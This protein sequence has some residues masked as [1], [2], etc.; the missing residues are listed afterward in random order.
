MSSNWSAALPNWKALSVRCTSSLGGHTS[1]AEQGA[2]IRAE[3]DE[4]YA[5]GI[6]P[7]RVQ[8]AA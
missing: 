3:V 2:L 7:L 6:E 8:R 5:Q 1:S 4:F